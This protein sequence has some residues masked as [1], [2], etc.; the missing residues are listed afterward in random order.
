MSG[1]DRLLQTKSREP[2]KSRIE[3]LEEIFTDQFFGLDLDQ[4]LVNL[5]GFCTYL[6]TY[7]RVGATELPIPK[8]YSI[9]APDQA[10]QGIGSLWLGLN[11]ADKSLKL[12]T[13]ERRELA[14]T[15]LPSKFD[16]IAMNPPY[17]SHRLMPEEIRAFLK[18]NYESSQYDLYAAFIELALRKLAEGGRLA[19]ICQQS[20]LTVQ[21]YDRL[22]QLVMQESAIDGVVQLGS[23]VFS[24]KAGEKVNNAIV[25]LEKRGICA[26]DH[27][28]CWRI[29]SRENKIDAETKGIDS[30]P[31]RLV[32]VATS[33]ALFAHIPKSPLAFWAPAEI[34]TLFAIIPLCPTSIQESSAPT[35]C[36]LATTI[37]SLGVSIALRKISLSTTFHTTKAEDISGTTPHRC[38]CFGKMGG[39]RSEPTD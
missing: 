13:L 14:L 20:F 34:L 3:S 9:I 35:V 22:R 38:D 16:A 28:K 6:K 32:P 2:K 27:T 23:G 4:E 39:L 8:I 31:A 19:T 37:S 17:L 10:S 1:L 5:A 18:R 7:D 24:T 21:R 11:Q 29:L 33:H 26:S 25:V 30:L 15:E 12:R 36:S